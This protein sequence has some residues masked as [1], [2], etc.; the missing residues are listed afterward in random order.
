MDLLAQAG[1]IDD[2]PE[3]DADMARCRQDRGAL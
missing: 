3:D 2:P 1:A